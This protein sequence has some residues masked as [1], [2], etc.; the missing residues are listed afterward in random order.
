MKID[1]TGRVKDDLHIPA[2]S[3]I[4][5]TT[6]PFESTLLKKGRAQRFFASLKNDGEG[7]ASTTPKPALILNFR[8][9]F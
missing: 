6:S 1:G 5:R 4:H 9:G 7:N 3:K 8:R 2:E